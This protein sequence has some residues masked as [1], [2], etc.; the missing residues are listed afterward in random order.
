MG[1]RAPHHKIAR[2]G[3]NACADHRTDHPANGSAHDGPR[4]ATPRAQRDLSSNRPHHESARAPAAP[5]PAS[6]TY[7][8]GYTIEYR[9]YRVSTTLINVGTYIPH[10]RVAV[11]SDPPKVVPAIRITFNEHDFYDL[12][13]SRPLTTWEGDILGMVL[14]AAGTPSDATERE[15]Q[16]L[17]F[18]IAEC[19]SCPSI[20]L[21]VPPVVRPIRSPAGPPH[22]QTGSAGRGVVARDK[23]GMPISVIVHIRHGFIAGIEI[24]R[25]DG[26]R[27]TTIPPVGQFV[28]IPAPDAEGIFHY[29]WDT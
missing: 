27:I 29:P 28:P 11:S 16:A 3:A 22:P 19:S 6:P 21:G 25:L 9:A 14:D 2:R 4:G 20:L 12:P 5:G 8:N 24:D 18:V 23:D 1:V 10:L 7:K 26:Q 17:V 13:T 15:Q